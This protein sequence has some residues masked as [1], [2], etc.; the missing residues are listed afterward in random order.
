MTNKNSRLTPIIIAISVVIGILIGSL[1][2]EHFSGNRLGIINSSSNKINALLRII[3]DQYVDDVPM[4]Q[5]VENAMPLILKEL[6]PHSKYIRAEDLEAENSGLEGKFSGIGVGFQIMNDTVC[7]N[8]IIPGG[9]SEKVGIMPGDHIVQIND[10][11]FTGANVDEK[12]VKSKLKA[13]KGTKVKITVKRQ[14]DKKLHSFTVIRGDIPVKSVDAAYMLDKNI[15][16]LRISQFGRTTHMEM[17]NSLA[18]LSHEGMKKVIID[19]RSNSGGYMEAAVQMANEFLPQGRLIVYM[20]GRKYPRSDEYSNGNGSF[21]KIPLVVLI[22]EASASASEIFAGAIQDN[23][24]GLIIGR[25]SF[26]KGL[27]QQ[28]IEFNDGSAIRL[29]IARYYTP[30]GRCIQRPYSLGI[31][32][33]YEKDVL[34]RYEHGEFFHA[35]SIHLDRTKTFYTSFLK[36]PVYAQSGIMPDIFISEDTL[37]ITSWYLAAKNASLQE[38]FAF[39]YTDKNR[40]MLS[41]YDNFVELLTYLKQQA[42]IDKLAAYGESNGLKRRNLMIRKS[43]KRIE[44]DLYGFLIYNI[45][46]QE[47]SIEFANLTDPTVIQAAKVLQENRSYPKAPTKEEKILTQKIDSAAR[48]TAKAKAKAAEKDKLW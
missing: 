26:G 42:L 3:S 34:T 29:T 10:S 21:Q 46:G 18:V 14:G 45:L 44:K 38:R 30:S 17:I 25:R 11:T 41:E 37:G 19:L 36:R 43:Q 2:T 7:I 48:A 24:R 5:I 31:D 23:D 32:E 9:P 35:D 6:D 40:K 8:S 27:V 28:P 13:K 1:Y 22:N 47:A 39:E 20:E 12:F 16:Y 4:D 15:G 33:A